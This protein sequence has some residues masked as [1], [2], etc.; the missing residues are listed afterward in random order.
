MGPLLSRARVRRRFKAPSYFRSRMK[1]RHSS[2][3]F[4][5]VGW[6]TGRQSMA[7]TMPRDVDV[8]RS[9]KRAERAEDLLVEAVLCP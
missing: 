4:E 6:P 3:R 5:S 8:S 1:H 7:G 9:G 2:M